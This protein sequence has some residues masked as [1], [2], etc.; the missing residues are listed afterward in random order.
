VWHS[1]AVDRVTAGLELRSVLAGHVATAIVDAA[2]YCGA[3]LIVLGSRGRS[4]LSA[5]L[6][7]SSEPGS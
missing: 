1:P 6:P 4:D 3:G 7:G 2:E 5:L